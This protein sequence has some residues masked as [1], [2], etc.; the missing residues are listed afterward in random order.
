VLAPPAAQPRRPQRPWYVTV[1]FERNNNEYR[2]GFVSSWMQVHVDEITVPQ[3]TGLEFRERDPRSGESSC[4]AIVRPSAFAPSLIGPGKRSQITRIWITE[5]HSFVLKSQEL[6]RKY[7]VP[8]GHNASAVARD[9]EVWRAETIWEAIRSILIR[10]ANDGPR[11]T[12]RCTKLGR[13]PSC[14]F[15]STWKV[16]FPEC[17]CEQGVPTVSVASVIPLQRAVLQAIESE[18]QRGAASAFPAGDRVGHAEPVTPL[19]NGATV[20]T[21]AHSESIDLKVDLHI[22]PRSGLFSRQTPPPPLLQETKAARFDVR[23]FRDRMHLFPDADGHGKNAPYILRGVVD[24]KTYGDW[25]SPQGVIILVIVRSPRDVFRTATVY[26]KTGLPMHPHSV[27]DVTERLENML[28][29]AQQ[30]PVWTTD[31][32][33]SCKLCPGCK[34]QSLSCVSPLCAAVYN[35]EK[36]NFDGFPYSFR[37]QVRCGCAHYCS[38]EC[39]D[40]SCRPELSLDQA[41]FCG[42]CNKEV[43]ELGSCSRFGQQCSVRNC[44]KVVCSEHRGRWACLSCPAVICTAC[45]EHTISRCRVEGCDFRTCRACR[46]RRVPKP[47]LCAQEH[48]CPWCDQ[49]LGDKENDPDTTGHPC[50]VCGKEW[51]FECFY[52]RTECN[53]TCPDCKTSVCPECYYCDEKGPKCC[54]RAMVDNTRY[55]KLRNMSHEL[56][57]QASGHRL[58]QAAASMRQFVHLCRTQTGPDGTRANV[59]HATEATVAH[60]QASQHQVAEDMKFANLSLQEWV[61]AATDTDGRCLLFKVFENDRHSQQLDLLV[62]CSRIAE[63]F[64]SVRP[65]ADRT[66]RVLFL[67]SCGRTLYALYR[68]FQWLERQ[69]R[70]DWT[71]KLQF[72]RAELDTSPAVELARVLFPSIVTCIARPP[73]Q[74]SSLPG[75]VF[76]MPGDYNI[77]Y[78]NFAGAG[79]QENVMNAINFMQSSLQRA[80]KPEVV[81]ITYATR[82]YCALVGTRAVDVRPSVVSFERCQCELCRALRRTFDC[83]VI[84]TGYK[85]VR[86]LILDVSTGDEEEEEEED[87]KM[88]E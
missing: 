28:R 78:L 11:V 22:P 16:W 12:T 67:D 76:E 65:D 69:K 31:E 64:A 5:Q 88:A 42:E 66:V 46:Q 45:N 4:I 23:L 20:S 24:Y 68:A 19:S 58:P 53:G 82:R 41:R 52:G 26:L 59:V 15:C 56:R 80:P 47:V 14:E 50:D 32:C 54:Q 37:K 27:F 87:C 81:A 55:Q 17:G 62:R 71:G 83:Q 43:S 9:D 21:A 1:V 8:S 85:R 60:A 2:D 63:A 77:V 38:E 6:P 25:L 39:R 10:G 18:D 51:C 36:S 57:Q 33:P 75:G 35:L 79:D 49:E 7:A 40:T 30:H 73:R 48:Q 70:A 72:V 86:T 29:A 84:G 61:N 13:A 44:S 34:K 74:S 3:V